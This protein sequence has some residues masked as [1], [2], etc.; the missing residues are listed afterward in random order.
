MSRKTE[1]ILSIAQFPPY[2]LAQIPLD[3]YMSKQQ[4]QSVKETS[5]QVKARQSLRQRTVHMGGNLGRLQW[6]QS[7]ENNPGN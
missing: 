6:F 2:T 5:W 4:D 3:L 7:L 1:R